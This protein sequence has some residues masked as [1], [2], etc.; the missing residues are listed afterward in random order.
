MLHTQWDE[1]NAVQDRD[2]GGAVLARYDFAGDE[3]VALWSA[4][5]GAQLL[6]ADALGSV[7]L[8]TNADGSVQSEVLFDAW[9]QPY[10]KRGSSSNKFG[11]T[12]HQMDAETGLHYFK[13][14]Y[15]DPELGRFISQ[16][17]AEG[18]ELRPASFQKYLYAYGNPLVWVDPDGRV[19]W[20]NAGADWLSGAGDWLRDRAGQCGSG[21]ICSTAGAAIGVSRAVVGLGE[22]GL[23]GVNV[24]ANTASLAAGTLGLNS[25]ANIDAHAAELE[26]TLNA[27]KAA[28]SMVSTSGGRQQLADKAFSTIEK[29][30][31][32]DAQAISDVSSFVAGAVGGR[33]AVGAA[34]GS[35]NAGQ[36]AVQVE[37]AAAREALSGTATAGK[38]LGEVAE[39]T[40]VK[41]VGRQT[42]EA[43]AGPGVRAA[44]P[45]NAV[46]SVEPQVSSAPVKQVD[47]PM[48]ASGGAASLTRRQYIEA[49]LRESAAGREASEF[50]AYAS[51]EQM[52]ARPAASEQYSVIMEAQLQQGV[53]FPGKVDYVHFQEAN[54]QLHT[55]M[56]AGDDLAVSLERAYP[57]MMDFSAPGA[58]GAFKG[59]TPAELGLTWHHHPINPGVLQLIPT[60]HHKASGAVQRTLHPGG[61]GGMENWGGGGRK[62]K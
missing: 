22:F 25:Q 57:G 34:S 32:G 48:Y 44:G 7:V 16:D 5:D 43:S 14:R 2:P 29:A 30:L 20:L 45:G 27:G 53:H 42:A 52:L 6:H 9:G 50:G 23:R 56:S 3:P 39:A 1:L 40:S 13:A 12:G 60:V 36:V 21:L 28:V 49:N 55:V 31:D 17:P 19:S 61:K 51:R 24:V 54:R 38:A 10:L 46:K 35:R 41:A 47:Q 15:Y 59:R 33:S 11:F 8:T 18:Q 62:R 4:E 37:K 26:G 58:R